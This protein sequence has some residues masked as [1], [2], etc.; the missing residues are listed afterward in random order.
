MSLHPHATILCLRGQLHLSFAE[1][2]ND[3]CRRSLA[4]AL[5]MLG[6]I[7]RVRMRDA[8]DRLTMD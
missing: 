4:E 3:R 7:S 1:D 8:F 5:P 2:L 6:D